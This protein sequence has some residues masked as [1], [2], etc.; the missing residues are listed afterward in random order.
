MGREGGGKRQKG[1][2]KKKKNL[3]LITKTLSVFSFHD[4]KWRFFPSNKI[5]HGGPKFKL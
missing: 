1:G 3:R 2:R 5:F 4:L